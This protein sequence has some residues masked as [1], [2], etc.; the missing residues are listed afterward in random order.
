MLSIA[1]NPHNISPCLVIMMGR[2]LLERLE[3]LAYSTEIFSKGGGIPPRLIPLYQELWESKKRAQA[4]ATTARQT[5]FYE[6]F[7]VT[8]DGEDTKRVTSNDSAGLNSGRCLTANPS[9]QQFEFGCK[10][11][12]D[13]MLRR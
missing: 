13:V 5:Y 2:R 3:R 11:S 12:R 10:T 7:V 4:T 8:P 9:E 1:A 6:G